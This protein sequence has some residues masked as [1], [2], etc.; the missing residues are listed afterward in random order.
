MTQIVFFY[1]LDLYHIKNFTRFA[2]E[3][4]F[5]LEKVTVEWNIMTMEISFVYQYNKV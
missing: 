4:F 1:I 5:G 3:S 2:C